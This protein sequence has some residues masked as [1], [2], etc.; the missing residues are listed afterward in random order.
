MMKFDTV[1]LSK[2]FSRDISVN[3]T[4]INKA[5][6]GRNVTLFVLL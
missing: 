5:K 6:S 3:K 2:V 1:R 4:T